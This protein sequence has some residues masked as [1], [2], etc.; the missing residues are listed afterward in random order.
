MELPVTYQNETVGRLSIVQQGLYYQFEAACTVACTEPLRLYA[1]C[2][3]QSKPIGVLPKDGAFT[4]R[5]SLR[6]TGE[7]PQYAVL[8]NA[9]NGFFPWRGAVEEE[10]VTD[11]YLKT[12]DTEM[13]LALPVSDGKEVPLIGHAGQMTPVTVCGRACLQLPLI[14]GKPVV[15]ELPDDEAELQP[16]IPDR[17]L[18]EALEIL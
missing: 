13:L 9:D 8:G 2:G 1:V 7:L 18:F 4:K 5:I 16:Q 15:P 17:M 6:E 12:G 3:L 14:D 11:A 10:T